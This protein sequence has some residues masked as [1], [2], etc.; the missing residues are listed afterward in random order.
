MECLQYVVSSEVE[1]LNELVLNLII[2]GIPS[3]LKND[4]CSLN[5]A[6]SVLNLIITGIPSILNT[7]LFYY[8][9][10]HSF[11]PYYNWNAFNTTNQRGSRLIPSRGFKPCYNWNTFNTLD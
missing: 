4:K 1:R 5:C 9:R 3:I 7:Y 2:T 10:Q 11:K 6:I 8:K